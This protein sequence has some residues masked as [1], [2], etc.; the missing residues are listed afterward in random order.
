MSGLADW[1][2]DSSGLTPHGFCLLWKPGLIWTYALSD[3]VIGLAYFSIPVAL[4]VVARR[5]GDLIFRPLL[6]SPLSFCCAARPIGS[7][8]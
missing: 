7:T 8:C 3:T 4:V 1:L 6:S 2:F 5:R